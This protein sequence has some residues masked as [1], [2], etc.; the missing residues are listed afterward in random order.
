MIF[1]LSTVRT[2]PPSAKLPRIEKTTTPA[3]AEVTEFR[4]PINQASL[5]MIITL[6]AKIY[7][8][9]YINVRLP[10]FFI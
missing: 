8:V 9:K 1:T 6:L 10:L 4:I 7:Y 2:S 5:Q 3:N